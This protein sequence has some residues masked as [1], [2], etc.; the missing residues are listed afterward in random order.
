M[1]DWVRDWVPGDFGPLTVPGS[2]GTVDRDTRARCVPGPHAWGPGAG[3]ALLVGRT[4][5]PT[6]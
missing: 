1:R 6:R 3:P 5:T 4:Y 2:L